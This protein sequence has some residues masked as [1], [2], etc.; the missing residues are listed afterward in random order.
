MACGVVNM[1][2]ESMSSFTNDYDYR[3]LASESMSNILKPSFEKEEIEEE[4]YHSDEEKIQ[5]SSS[6]DSD[7]SV[8]GIPNNDEHSTNSS[9]E[10]YFYDEDNLKLKLEQESILRQKKRRIQQVNFTILFFKIF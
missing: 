8:H 10:D 6:S 7:N 1:I 9:E 4:P 3:N 5:S 2:K